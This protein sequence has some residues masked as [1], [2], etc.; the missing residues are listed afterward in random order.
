MMMTCHVRPGAKENRI[1][2]L[3]ETE[4][5]VWLTAA[6]EKGKANK[7]LIDILARELRIAKSRIEIKYGK[8]AKVKTIEIS[9]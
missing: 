3:S 9:A 5:K 1:E 7:A 6:P 4:A 8:T 2:W